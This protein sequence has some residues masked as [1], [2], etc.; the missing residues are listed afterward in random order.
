[1][2]HMTKH[3][4]RSQKLESIHIM[5]LI[6]QQ[7]NPKSHSLTHDQICN[8]WPWNR[9]PVSKRSGFNERF[10]GSL[11]VPVF[12]TIS[13]HCRKIAVTKDINTQYKSLLS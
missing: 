8:L 10:F 7:S 4:N 12:L 13:E 2:R 1:M 11:S 5:R 3:M 6:V 9:C